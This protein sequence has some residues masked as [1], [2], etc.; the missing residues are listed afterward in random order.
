MKHYII[1]AKLGDDQSLDAIKGCFTA[2]VFAEALRACQ[3]AID[4]TKS[5]QREAAVQ[6]LNAP[7]LAR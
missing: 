4:E 2:D 3:A 5:P 7:G 1:A 6:K